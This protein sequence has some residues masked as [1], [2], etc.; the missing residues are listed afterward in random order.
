MMSD[1]DVD[2]IFA[3][4]VEGLP[5]PDD[6]APDYTALSKE[7]ILEQ[8]V[9]TKNALENHR[10]LLNPTTE[11]DRDLQAKYYGLLLEMRKRNMK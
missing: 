7:E 1:E 6:Q 5:D 8:W 10:A 2:S 9:Q 4:M 3:E 11:E